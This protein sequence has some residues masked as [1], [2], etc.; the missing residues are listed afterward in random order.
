LR[1]TGT[2]EFTDSRSSTGNNSCVGEGA[3]QSVGGFG[4]HSTIGNQ[5]CNN[6]YACEFS[7]A[8]PDNSSRIGN[9]SC[10]GLTDFTDPDFPI[11]ICD[12]NRGIIGNNQRNGP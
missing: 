1:R 3:C 4:G 6:D 11:G 9:H 2:D 10:N 7:G 8:E 5:S 12:T